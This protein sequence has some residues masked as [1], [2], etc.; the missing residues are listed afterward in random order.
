MINRDQELIGLPYTNMIT[1]ESGKT[2]YTVEFPD[3]SLVKSLSV[4]RKLVSLN[5]SFPEFIMN[6]NGYEYDDLPNCPVCNTNKVGVWG[7]IIDPYLRH[8]CDHGCAKSFVVKEKIK[9]GTHNLQNLSEE[10][11]SLRSKKSANTQLING[12]LSLLNLSKEKYSERAV[13]S[14]STRISEN[15]HNFLSNHKDRSLIANKSVET[16]LNNGI[17]LLGSNI[18]EVV[19][20]VTYNFN[21]YAEVRVFR[22]YYRLLSKLYYRE[23]ICCTY[24]IDNTNKKYVADY[25]I[26]SKRFNLPDVIEVK[27]SYKDFNKINGKDYTEINYQKFK[28][29]INSNKTLL[30]INN[31]HYRNIFHYICIIDDLNK[32]YNRSNHE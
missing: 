18:Y 21:S 13:K 3:G 7:R 25:I 19:N 12:S 31:Q 2:V 26:K 8:T 9:N 11:K 22:R 29:V 14:N 27:S 20:G 10:C 5:K 16:K 6:I 4:N 17:S 1:M 32:L 30:I 15:T 23:K 24:S 28:S